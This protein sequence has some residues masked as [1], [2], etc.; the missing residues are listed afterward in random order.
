MQED[1]TQQLASYLQISIRHHSDECYNGLTLDNYDVWLP[2]LQPR[3]EY[4]M[5]FSSSSA[6]TARAAAAKSEHAKVV[7][8]EIQRHIV[9][10]LDMSRSQPFPGFEIRNWACF[11][12]RNVGDGKCGGW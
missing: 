4:S 5:I 6:P 11:V 7:D 12:F 10:V 9:L 8:E 2:S 1:R 3:L